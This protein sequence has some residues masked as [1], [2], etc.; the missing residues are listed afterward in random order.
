VDSERQ[1]FVGPRPFEKADKEVFFGRDHETTELLS[2]IVAHPVVLL[3]AQSGAGKTSMLNAGL[4]PALEEEGLEVFPPARVSG[5]DIRATGPDSISNIYIFNALTCWIDDSQEPEELR[6]LSLAEFLANRDHIKDEDGLPLLRVIIFDQFEE[7]FTSHQEF[8]EHRKAFF[9]QIRIALEGEQSRRSKSEQLE[10]RLKGD[11]LLRVLLVIREDYLAQMDSYAPLLPEKLRTRFRIERLREEAALAAVTGPLRM[12]NSRRVFAPGVAEKLVKDLTKIR[13]ETSAGQTEVVM[14]EFVEPVQLQVVCRR[15]LEAIPE[16]V[17]EITEENLQDFGDVG[18]AL[19]VFYEECLEK[20]VSKAG[21]KEATLRLWFERTLITPAGTRGTVFIG[22]SESG[23]IPASAVKALEDLHLIRGEWRAGAKWYELTHDRLIEPIQESN[24]KWLAGRLEAEQTRQRLEAKAAEWVRLGRSRGGL[25]DE[26]ELLEV[27]RALASP[28]AAEMGFSADLEALVKK[29]REAIEEARLEK[30]AA[31]SREL[32][33]A[34]AIAE[35]QRQRAEQQSRA[36]KYSGLFSITLL[37]LLVILIIGALIFNSRS[38]SQRE[39]ERRSQLLSAQSI[40]LLDEQPDL[41][42]LLSAEAYATSKTFEARSSLLTGLDYSSNITSFLHGHDRPVNSVVFS[43]DGKTLASVSGDLRSEEN[44]D[45]PTGEKKDSIILW[46]VDANKRGDLHF[47]YNDAVTSVAF[48]PDGKWLATG[49]KDGAVRLWNVATAQLDRSFTNHKGP[50]NS[51]AFSPDGKTL[52]SGGGDFKIILWD[53][54]TGQ[55][56]HTL[57]GH[58]DAISSVTFSPD[59]SLLA[60]GSRDTSIILWDAAT[61][62]RR[63]KPLKDHIDRVNAVVFSPDGKTL[64]S[65]S[66]DTRIILW[67]IATGKGNRLANLQPAIQSLAFSPDGALLVPGTKNGII[68]IDMATGKGT[69]L[70][71]HRGSVNSVAF[72][73]DGNRLASGSDD[74]SVILWSTT[75]RHKLADPLADYPRA[76][77]VSVAFNPEGK[78]A[79]GSWSN[80]VALWD[81]ATNKVKYLTDQKTSVYSIA[82]SPVRDHNRLAWGVNSG[83]VFLWDVNAGQQIGDPLIGHS[84]RITSLAFSPDGKIL[85][86]ASRDKSIILWDVNTGKPRIGPLLGHED[87]ITSLAF[88]PDGSTL[89]SGSWDKS[90][91]LWDV[92]TGQSKTLGSHNGRVTSIAYSPDGSTLA[93]AGRDKSIILWDV[94][95]RQSKRFTGHDAGITSLAF[96]PDGR[97]LASGGDDRSIVLWNVDS[98]NVEVVMQKLGQP[99]TGH[100][101]AINSLAFSADGRTLASGS[102]ENN[103]VILWNIDSDSWV[104]L[105]C[106]VTNRSMTPAECKQYLGKEEECNACKN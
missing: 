66:T 70:P 69:S 92:A 106:A 17:T 37:A 22:Q 16:D 8:R 87:V 47:D 42:L 49:G 13:V 86:S 34:Q 43:P 6:R 88:S 7:I 105:V 77:A 72:S 33:L 23:G 103:A 78:L 54:A 21:V 12:T 74:Q 80:G 62:N 71:G 73:P 18:H 20:A 90:V 61:G 51:L 11:S 50:V 39:R 9:D 31:A 76:T 15:L 85:A 14:G 32:K 91:I 35:E 3:Y 94:A 96:S 98:A 53:V 59:G 5:T 68:L 82:F 89:A 100:F 36:A 95:R 60:S 81:F 46:D 101:E 4:I 99:L 27:E 65:G 1:P 102:G 63:G 58:S 41:A 67:D 93:S 45:A 84:A 48:S 29:S 25:L 40:S 30:E 2:L 64:A 97:M 104:K 75:A 79:L 28:N 24:R 26:V 52:A 10:G 83:A 38:S 55:P 56:R 57:P 44:V 19:M